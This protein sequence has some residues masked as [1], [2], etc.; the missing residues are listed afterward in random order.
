MWI[1]NEL[2]NDFLDM[3]YPSNNEMIKIMLCDL[4]ATLSSACLCVRA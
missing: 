3:N 1:H 2:M 4:A